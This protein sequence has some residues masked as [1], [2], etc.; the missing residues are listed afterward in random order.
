M[1]QGEP[2]WTGDGWENFCNELLALHHPD[3]YQVIPA[4]DRGDCGLEGHS[5]DDQGCGYQCYA[6]DADI[7][8]GERRSRQVAKITDTVST[9]IEQRSRLGRVLGTHHIQRLIFLFPRHDSAEVN[10]HLRKQEKLLREA[11]DQHEIESIRPDVVLAAWTIPPY[12]TT[13]R[14]EL[15]RVGGAKA[16]LPHVEVDAA[17][18]QRY[19]EEA[20]K[21]LVGTLE[22][23]ERRFGSS[24]APDILDI[25]L[26]D[27]L[28]ADEQERLLEKRPNSYEKYQR[29]K[30]QE[31]HA[32]RR[33][34]AEGGTSSMTLE[35]VRERLS[36]KIE[37]QVPGMD[38]GDVSSLAAGVVSNWLVECPL[39]FP[40]GTEP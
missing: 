31:R 15:E 33:L 12:L 4:H 3:A 29:L 2:L 35:D 38:D 9:L 7:D 30:A 32:I 22:K 14:E 1:L 26:E 6:A 10:G 5:T 37:G 13:E 11:V 16:P 28:I 20:A 8:I 24:K 19:R 34:T 17:E 25:A 40:D 23:L 21:P 18:L 27:K 39:D 36:E